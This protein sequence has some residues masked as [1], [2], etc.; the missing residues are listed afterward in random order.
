MNASAPDWGTTMLRCKFQ[1]V[2]IDRESVTIRDVGGTVEQMTV[3]NDAE[4]V[5]AELRR[6]GVLPIGKR[7]FYYDSD[8]QLDEILVD[9]SGFRGFAPVPKHRNG[10]RDDG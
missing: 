4:N 10:D 1:V 9:V 3:T 7:L 6:S 5:V 2:A 8:G